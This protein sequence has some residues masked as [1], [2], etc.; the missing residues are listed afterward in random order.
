MKNIFIGLLFVFVATHSYARVKEEYKILD[1]ML[2]EIAKALEV[3]HPSRFINGAFPISNEKRLVQ[4]KHSYRWTGDLVG[5]TKMQGIVEALEPYIK[6]IEENYPGYTCKSRSFMFKEHADEYSKEEIPDLSL[7]FTGGTGNSYQE[8]WFNIQF[9]HTSPDIL[10]LNAVAIQP[11]QS[12]AN[13]A[14]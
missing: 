2:L 6:K 10:F 7:G 3:A 14:E 1:G 13:K 5:E 11:I 12:D 8:M 4:M 9:I